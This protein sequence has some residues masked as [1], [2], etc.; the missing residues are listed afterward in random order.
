[1]NNIIQKSVNAFAWDFSGKLANNVVMFI[2][3]IFMARLLTPADFGLIGMV[4]AFI[5]L[6]Q[7]FVDVGLTG[8]IVQIKENSE[9]QISTI[10]YINIALGII[11]TLLMYNVAPY[12]SMYYKT[13]ELIPITKALSILFL[14]N[15]LKVTQNAL[16]IKNLS[17]K[18]L[19][20]AQFIASLFSGVLA[21]VLAY[22]GY[23]VWSMVFRTLLLYVMITLLTWKISDWRP[24]KLFNIHS[25]KSHWRYGNK[26]LIVGIIDQI[27]EKIDVLLIG[28][29]FGEA[30]LGLYYRAKSLNDLIIRITSSSFSIVLFPIFSQIQDDKIFIVKTLI[31]SLT[32][33]SFVIF[34]IIGVVYLLADEIILLLYGAKWI[35]SAPYLKIIVFSSSA[36]PLFYVLINLLK[37][38][39]DS[40]SILILTLVNKTLLSV[41]LILAFHYAGIYGFLWGV[42]ISSYLNM[43]STM[44]Y[45]KKD[46]GVE[47]KSMVTPI[48]GYFLIASFVVVIY[49]AICN[50]INVSGLIYI[51]I[52]LIYFP[53]AYLSLNKIF[54]TKGLQIFRTAIKNING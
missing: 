16:L 47:I 32:I 34:P 8:A 27:Y 21:V 35:S 50:I 40:K 31:K 2:I 49:L 13:E 33:L 42:V 4:M 14:L 11:L 15:S 37:G 48:I 9:E 43:L 54:N 1:M 10:F 29:V 3:S 30:R 17:F 12:I 41:S 18:A 36:I 38:I 19:A 26:L 39:G 6:S 25:I 45:V 44:Y 5:T 28:R 51:S 53:I 20:K 7:G 24:K 23:G 46:L 22:L 52:T